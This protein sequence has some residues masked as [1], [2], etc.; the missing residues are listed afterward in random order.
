MQPAVQELFIQDLQSIIGEVAP[1]LGQL[2]QVLAGAVLLIVAI[3]ASVAI[4]SAWRRIQL[5]EPPAPRTLLLE[6]RDPDRGAAVHEAFRFLAHGGRVSSGPPGR[7][8][9]N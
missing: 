9:R 8:R 4:V 3:S 1:L 2:F 6:L 7:I 5:K